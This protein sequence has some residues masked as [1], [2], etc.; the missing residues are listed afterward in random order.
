MNIENQKEYM[1]KIK[2]INE[3]KNLKYSIFT[4]GCQ[5]NEND[6]EKLCGMLEE[7]N[8]SKTENI[9]DYKVGVNISGDIDC[10]KY[11]FSTDII[12]FLD[13]AK[14]II[15]NVELV[16]NNEADFDMVITVKNR[17]YDS[18]NFKTLI[19]VK[20]KKENTEDKYYVSAVN[21]F[22]EWNIEV[23]ESKPKG[24]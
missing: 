2:K 16:K 10:L 20:N 13:K 9:N 18:S 7:M 11:V 4:M 8:Y 19:T 17:G 22:K 3:G 23:L 14:Q 5:L 1:E 15:P 24:W 12:S 6:S 21:E